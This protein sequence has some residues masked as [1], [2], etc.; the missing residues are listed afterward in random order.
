MRRRLLI[1][2]LLHAES[3]IRKIDIEGW[4]ERVETLA[5]LGEVCWPGAQDSV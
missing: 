2:S 3:Y 4:Q 5:D 1:L